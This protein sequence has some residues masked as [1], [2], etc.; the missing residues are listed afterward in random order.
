MQRGGSHQS[1]TGAIFGDS[2]GRQYQ[3][4][5][6]ASL[7]LLEGSYHPSGHTILLWCSGSAVSFDLL[8]AFGRKRIRTLAKTKHQ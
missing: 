5:R 2:L 4:Q 6:K 8:A 3:K 1:T 7:K